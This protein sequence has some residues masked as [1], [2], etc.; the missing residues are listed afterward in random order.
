MSDPGYLGNMPGAIPS[1]T[2]ILQG[3]GVE[4]G[5]KHGGHYFNENIFVFY[6]E[7]KSTFEF[8]INSVKRAFIDM[9]DSV[10]SRFIDVEP[11]VFKKSLQAYIK[12]NLTGPNSPNYEFVRIDR[13]LSEK[14]LARID[15]TGKVSL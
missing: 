2:L 15:S 11:V 5:N 8:S 10:T 1:A 6:N 4:H 9:N 7:V 13:D 12:F 3:H 14:T